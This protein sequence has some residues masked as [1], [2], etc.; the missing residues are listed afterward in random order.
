[1]VR[2]VRADKDIRLTSPQQFFARERTAV[3]EA[4][5]GDVV[6]VM[7]RGSLRIGDTLSADVRR[8][9]D[10]IPRFSPEHFATIIVP[11]PLRRKHLDT[12]LRH[13]SEE[14]A[15][16]VFY[17]DG[18]TGPQPIVGAVGLLQFD[19]LLH[20]LLG[21]YGV[22]A[23]LERLPYRV[24]RWVVGEDDEIR[25]VAAVQDRGLVFD[26]KERPL[27]LFTSDW[28]LRVAVDRSETLVFH[29]VAP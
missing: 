27:L 18:V 13:L 19:V 2:N 15:A 16:Q 8:A 5:A 10:D 12:G 11:D 24:A 7:D 3:D 26:A 28:A 21:E 6:G 1:V 25:R 23:R 17:R 9:F 20:R 29:E 14:G 22:E 4:W